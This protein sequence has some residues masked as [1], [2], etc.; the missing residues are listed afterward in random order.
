MLKLRVSYK[1]WGSFKDTQWIHCSTLQWWKASSPVPSCAALVPQWG[2]KR[3]K[4]RILTNASRCNLGISS[5]FTPALD[6][7]ISQKQHG[8]I[9]ASPTVLSLHTPLPLFS[10]ANAPS[11]KK[12]F[13]EHILAALAQRQT[14]GGWEN[15]CNNPNNFKQVSQI[16]DCSWCSKLDIS[17]SICMHKHQDKAWGFC[18]ILDPLF[19]PLPW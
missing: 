8:S 10:S 9:F 13:Y 6:K 1:M 15:H 7:S 5:L 3:E 4:G 14:S 18:R 16:L 19:G 17:F 11:C 2:E 12:G